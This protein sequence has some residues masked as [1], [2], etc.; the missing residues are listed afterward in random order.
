MFSALCGDDHVRT[1]STITRKATGPSS[2]RVKMRWRVLDEVGVG[3]EEGLGECLLLLAQT[4][5]VLGLG[6]LLLVSLFDILL[7]SRTDE[8]LEQ[9]PQR[10]GRNSRGRRRACLEV[11]GGLA[12]KGHLV[13]RPLKFVDARL[14]QPRLI[15]AFLHRQMVSGTRHA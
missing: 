1:K 11:V 13:E 3:G 14:R 6:L 9:D 12:R 2:G 7:Q 15:F 8:R 10:C 5:N 4:G